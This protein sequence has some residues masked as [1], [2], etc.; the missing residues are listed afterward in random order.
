VVKKKAIFFD[1][2]GVLNFPIIKKK[3]PYAPLSIKQFKLY[4]NLEKYNKKIRKKEYLIF[5]IT[6]QP[7]FR[8][9]KISTKILNK[10]NKI[11]YEKFKYNKIY[12]S[13]SKNDNNYFRKPNPGMIMKAKNE[14]NLDLNKSFI[15][16]DRFSDIIIGKKLNI[17]SI[18]IDRNYKEKKPL[19]QICTVKNIKEAVNFILKYKEKK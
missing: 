1:R 4:K 19:N 17:K 6:N 13:L 10:L 15:I 16:G 3:K 11:L 8:K 5:V 7:D 14:F 12:I 2:D 18:F 9:K